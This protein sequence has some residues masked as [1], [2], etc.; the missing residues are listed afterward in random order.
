MK[1]TSS[2][3]VKTG[4]QFRTGSRRRR[5]FGKINPIRE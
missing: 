3:A 4:K 2:E 5:R 1:S